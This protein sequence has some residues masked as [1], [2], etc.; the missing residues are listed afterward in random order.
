MSQA[1]H[2]TQIGRDDVLASIMAEQAGKDFTFKTVADISMALPEDDV[3][4]LCAA[5]A[6]P[7]NQAA[8]LCIRITDQED[9]GSY[10]EELRFAKPLHLAQILD[11]AINGARLRQRQQPRM[12]EKD[13]IFHPFARQI[14]YMGH[15]RS[16]TLTQKEA[17]FLCAVLDA[18]EQGLPRKEA[19]TQLWGYHPDVESH[20]VD[21]TL[22]RLRQ[23]L[24]ELGDVETRLMNENGLYKWRGA[25]DDIKSG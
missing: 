14:I 1:I 18:G 16:V 2:I 10:D 9:R 11:A 24:Q 20:A 19:M 17:V 5:V 7:L 8:P 23:K 15:D 6:S 21:T 13:C 12:L 3:W 22:Y 25:A 4:L